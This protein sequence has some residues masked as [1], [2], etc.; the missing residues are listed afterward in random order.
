MVA[1]FGGNHTLPCNKPGDL[2]TWI[3]SATNLVMGSRGVL[4]R[5][6]VSSLGTQQ[7]G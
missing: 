7:A 6:T 3:D 1:R 2:A 5:Y 4:F